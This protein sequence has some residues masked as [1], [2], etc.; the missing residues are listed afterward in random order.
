MAQ[1]QATAQD[2]QQY[3]ACTP[4]AYSIREVDVATRSALAPA[5]YQRLVSEV[6][7]VEHFNPLKQAVK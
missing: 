5:D 2:K 3:N 1:V 7:L 6:M 4:N